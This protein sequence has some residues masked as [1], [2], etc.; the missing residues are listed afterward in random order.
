[1]LDQYNSEQLHQLQKSKEHA[2]SSTRYTYDYNHGLIYVQPVNASKL[3]PTSY[4]MNYRIK[5][6]NHKVKKQNF[7][8][9]S[10]VQTTDRLQSSQIAK[11]DT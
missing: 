2:S 5:K 6:A 7:T 8:V 9:K 3:P 1:L 11:L 10:K 4:N